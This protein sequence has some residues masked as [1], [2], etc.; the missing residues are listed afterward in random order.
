MWCPELANVPNSYIH[1]PW[2]M[3]ASVKKESGVS[4]VPY[5]EGMKAPREKGDI[6]PLPIKCDKYTSA[7]AAKKMTRTDGKQ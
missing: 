4:I 3:P 6:Y 7:E 1:D 5:K 2:N